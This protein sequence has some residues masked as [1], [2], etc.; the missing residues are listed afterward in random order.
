M[1]ICFFFPLLLPKYVE[2]DSGTCLIIE[3]LLAL[4]LAGRDDGI[5][6]AGVVSGFRTDALTIGFY[7]L[8][9]LLVAFWQVLR[10][11]CAPSQELLMDVASVTVTEDIYM[12]KLL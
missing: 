1:F 2:K 3:K 5:S 8:Q 10:A 4:V 9:F 11:P 6:G 7:P 12:T